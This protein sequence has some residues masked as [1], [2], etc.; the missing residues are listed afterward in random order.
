MTTIKHLY[1]AEHHYGIEFCNDYSTLYRFATKAE[2]DSFV[3]NI[4]FNEAGMY[5]GY[6][7]EAVTRAEARRHFPNAFKRLDVHDE[8]DERDW[9][10]SDASAYAYW[11][12]CNLWEE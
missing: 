1:A 2:R 8:A 12:T 9:H 10:E 6:C 11:S 4:N 7:T 3:E 5:G